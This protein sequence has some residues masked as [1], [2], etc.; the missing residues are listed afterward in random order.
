MPLPISRFSCLHR[1]TG[2]GL[3]LLTLS[4]CLAGPALGQLR[5]LRNPYGNLI[6]D[7]QFRRS[8]QSSYA[9]N[10]DVE[11]AFTREQ[12][13]DV[14]NELSTEIVPNNPEQAVN[15]INDYIATLNEQN[16]EVN[17]NF[18]FLL[19]TLHFQAGDLARAEDNLKQAVDVFPN[20]LRARKN[21]GLLYLQRED[22]RLAKRHLS[23]AVELGE[24]SGTN[25]GL[26]GVCYLQLEDYLSAESAF[27]QAVLLEPEK[28]E[29]Q[30]SLVQTLFLLENWPEAEKM[31]GS[32]IAEDPANTDN[33]ILQAQAYLGMEDTLKAAKNYEIVHALGEGS[34][35]THSTLADIYVSQGLVDL[36]ASEY[37]AA[38]SADPSTGLDGALRAAEILLAQGAQ[39]RAEELLQL[40]M[41]QGA[42]EL[43]DEDENKILQLEAQIQMESG[44]KDQAAETLEK[45]V[46]SDPTQGRALLKLGKYYYDTEDFIRA[47][48]K[49]EAAATLEDPDIQSDA[50][51]GLARVAVK[52]EK[53]DQA[54]SR[55][56]KAL[57]I[58]P[59]D[60]VRSY[61][62]DI[63]RTQRQ[64]GGG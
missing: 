61:L 31:I 10:S 16:V 4:L 24:I 50:N 25:F 54:I 37:E 55:L 5:N 46:A 39:S 15:L 12:D 59:S 30:R 53:Y 14:F 2:F 62:E 28:P 40:V 49:Y 21:L 43:S 57:S 47:Q 36:A 51:V 9:L 52:E 38:Y 42:G 44:N 64:K 45:V 23:K 58:R 17:A 29:W 35:E 32:L 8:L 18:Y 1:L 6:D 48:V 34:E 20:F 3:I 63:Q 13:E 27:R 22:F 41:N 56:E 19:G 11:P 26:L 7:P 33:W 60:A